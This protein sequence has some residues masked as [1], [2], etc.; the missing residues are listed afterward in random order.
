[1]SERRINSVHVAS[2]IQMGRI[3]M[4]TSNNSTVKLSIEGKRGIF[5]KS[6]IKF[7]ILMEAY[8]RVLEQQEI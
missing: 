5:S 4:V 6:L 3:E 8:C 7:I 1:M 2:V